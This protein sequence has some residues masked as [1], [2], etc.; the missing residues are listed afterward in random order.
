MDF[1]AWLIVGAFLP[2]GPRLAPLDPEVGS[3]CLG[4]RI[5]V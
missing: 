2:P 4:F 3:I 1:V 5:G